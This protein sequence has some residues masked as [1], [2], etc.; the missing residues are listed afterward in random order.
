[1]CELCRHDPCDPT[2]PNYS[3]APT[4]FYCVVCGEGI[5][6]GDQYIENFSGEKMHLECIRSLRE[7]LEWLGYDIKTMEEF[8]IYEG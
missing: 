5:H 3:P 6:A 2:C 8:E 1:M 4:D 7:L